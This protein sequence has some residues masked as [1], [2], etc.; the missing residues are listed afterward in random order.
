MRVLSDLAGRE[1]IIL[2]LVKN[3][4]PV[5]ACVTDAKNEDHLYLAQKLAKETGHVLVAHESAEELDGFELMSWL[6][7]WTCG[8][9]KEKL[10][11][12]PIHKTGVHL[13][14]LTEGAGVITCDWGGCSALA[15][16]ER[17]SETDGW[18]PVCEKHKSS[19]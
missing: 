15:V 18:L 13:R 5:S 1:S 6:N 11:E 7:T 3:G 4:H 14:P 8:K 9:T 12:H 2:I 17:V 16:L 10:R 19:R